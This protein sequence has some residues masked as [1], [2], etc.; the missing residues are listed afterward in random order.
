MPTKLRIPEDSFRLGAGRYIQCDG[1]VSLVGEEVCRLGAKRA[2]VIG[3]KTA[4]S[5]TENKIAKSLRE[6]GVD[7]VFYIYEGFCSKETNAEIMERED[8]RSSDVVIGVGGGTVMDAAKYCAVLSALPI[9]NIPTS[10]A[11]CAAYT[12]LSVC[13][14]KTGETVGTVHH[15]TEVNAV[16]CDM[17]ILSKQPERLLLA[18]IYDAMAKQY[19]LHQ[20]MLGIDIDYTDIGLVSSYHSS[21][22]IFDFLNRKLDE[23][24]ADVRAK[25][26]TKTV[27][28][29][30]YITIALTGVVSGLARGSN[31]TALAHKVYESLRR[32]YAEKVR[33]FL[34][35][36]LVALGLI[37]QIAYNGEGG[38]EEFRDKLR[39][40]SIPT[41]VSELGITDEGYM[42]AL[43]E[44]LVSS[45]AM[46]GTT[47][48]EKL[49]LKQKL[50]LIK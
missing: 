23:C 8:F 33:G 48:E 40:L 21:G 45:T 39:S 31:Q 15:K 19:E 32:L 3:G 37:V 30:V 24:L 22:F 41:S 47:D 18:G 49:R 28:D 29:T 6:N 10:S 50:L 26:N 2:F 20:R 9:I 11:T 42:D 7:F 35:G 4:L 38:E 13:Y 17:E 46:A 5:L 36:E 1:A 12:P 16:L 44:K 34:H 27:Y 43:Y 14:T 25:K